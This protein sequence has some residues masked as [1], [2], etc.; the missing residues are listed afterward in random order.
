MTMKELCKEWK[1]FSSEDFPSIEKWI[2][3]RKDSNNF[4]FGI[5]NTCING[6]DASISGSTHKVHFY[7]GHVLEFCEGREGAVSII[8]CRNDVK[9]EAIMCEEEGCIMFFVGAEGDF[10]EEL[11]CPEDCE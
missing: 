8:F 7:Q 3:D 11:G 10:D 6:F 1:S 5:H 4:I 9:Y 2:D